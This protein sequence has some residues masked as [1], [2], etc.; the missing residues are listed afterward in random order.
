MHARNQNE[1]KL[2]AP[3]NCA[4]EKDE[5]D[6]DQARTVFIRKKNKGGRKI[7]RLPI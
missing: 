7:L 1:S 6:D 4:I 5:E 3:E 2:N